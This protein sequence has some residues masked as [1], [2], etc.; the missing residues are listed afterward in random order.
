MLASSN[1]SEANANAERFE[2]AL[3]RS[4]GL[5]LNLGTGNDWKGTFGTNVLLVLPKKRLRQTSYTC[6]PRDIWGKCSTLP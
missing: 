2:A 3:L 1:E 5:R 6:C 4:F